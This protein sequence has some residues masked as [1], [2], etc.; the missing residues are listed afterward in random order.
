MSGGGKLRSVCGNGRSTQALGPMSIVDIT[1]YLICFLACVC[2]SAV[3]LSLRSTLAWSI[4]TA[5]LIIGGLAAFTRNG[6][7][8]L[9]L[10]G[11]TCVHAGVHIAQLALA[12]AIAA[13]VAA[14]A[15]RRHSSFVRATVVASALSFLPC[16]VLTSAASKCGCTAATCAESLVRLQANGA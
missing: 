14:I 5:L 9:W 3:F 16:A 12:V 15:A 8:M 1:A 7:Q 4:V 2:I 10:V 13:V 11:R 6:E